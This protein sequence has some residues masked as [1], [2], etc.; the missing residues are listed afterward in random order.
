MSYEYNPANLG[1]PLYRQASQ[2][3]Q[4]PGVIQKPPG[5]QPGSHPGSQPRTQPGSQSRSQPSAH[6]L[7][8]SLPSSTQPQPKIQLP[9]ST[10]SE[11]GR[12]PPS[13]SIVGEEFKFGGLLQSSSA[14]SATPNVSDFLGVLP[15]NSNEGVLP[16][17]NTSSSLGVFC[18]STSSATPNV[19]EYGGV[20]PTSNGGVLPN[21]SS[22]TPNVASANLLRQLVLDR[23]K[24]PLS[25]LMQVFFLGKGCNLKTQ[26]SLQEIPPNVVI[27]AEHAL[28][29]T[30]P[31]ICTNANSPPTSGRAGSSSP[32]PETVP[33]E[34][35]PTSP[36]EWN[37]DT[38]FTPSST[39]TVTEENIQK[40]VVTISQSASKEISMLAPNITIEYRGPVPTFSTPLQPPVRNFFQSK[41][42]PNDSIP[43]R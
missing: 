20:L 31:A 6:Q 2:T 35:K 40:P 10:S 1:N 11:G 7:P 38:L 18:S 8:I 41:F 30:I 24:L 19:A 26:N 12:L 36:M 4:C 22:A 21:R 14:G 42:F 29:A 43:T 39:T 37:P 9:T 23:P 5:S 17:S 33:V 32:E 3:E 25:R 34:S 15:R 28:V 16:I 27:S 13:R